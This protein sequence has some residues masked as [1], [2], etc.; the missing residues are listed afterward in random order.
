[1]PPLASQCAVCRS[2]P[3]D[4]VCNACTARFLGVVPRCRTCAEALPLDLSRGLRT[5]PGQCLTCIAHAPSADAV[6]V[7]VDYAYPWSALIAQY[8]FGDRPGWAP[9]F[10][11]LLLGAPGV[12]RALE[13]LAAADFIV[14]IPLAEPRLQTRGF[15][16]SW[17]LASA[18][19][20]QSGSPAKADAHLLL[21]IKN[22]RSQTDLLRAARLSNVV[23]VFAVDPLRAPELLHRRVVLVDDVM[24][25]GATLFAAAQ[26]IKSSGARHVTAIALARTPAP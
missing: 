14:P 19:A 26:A 5:S 12:L 23:G 4:P 7:A 20:M 1:M 24:T 21:R 6:L 11:K 17:E 25:S 9:Y 8:K 10:A 18:L 3:T 15:N 2:W 22:N 13:G 16:Q